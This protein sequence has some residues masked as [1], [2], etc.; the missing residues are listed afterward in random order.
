MA[1]QGLAPRELVCRRG[2]R[3]TGNTRGPGIWM[4][5]GG[6]HGS[7]GGERELFFGRWNQ[8][9]FGEDSEAFAWNFDG[10]GG[11]VPGEVDGEDMFQIDR[12]E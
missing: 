11:S 7:P 2:D 5:D 8:G 4:R 6:D 1:R 10:R 12:C 3:S 9:K